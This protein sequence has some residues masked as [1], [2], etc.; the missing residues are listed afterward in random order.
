MQ[1]NG[2]RNGPGKKH[3]ERLEAL[4]I[5]LPTPPIP[6]GNYVE[7][8]LVGTLLFTSGILPFVNGKLLFTGRLG[9]DLTLEQGQE[10]AR[11][12]ALNALAA[13]SHFLGDVDR[14]QKVVRVGIALATTESFTQHAGVADGASDLLA[15][16]FGKEQGHTR[17][18]SGVYSLP[19]RTP[20][21]LDAVFEVVV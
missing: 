17:L 7:T 14:I 20:V 8:S 3:S 9:A 4:G 11:Y 21:V 5:Q 1:A 16:I 18:V 19:V 2:N 13:A 10:A 15:Q 12:A 6:L